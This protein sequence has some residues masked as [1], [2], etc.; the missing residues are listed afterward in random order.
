MAEV[1]ITVMYPQPSDLAKFERDYLDEHIPMAKEVFQKAGATRAVLTKITGSPMG[2]PAFCRI[3][4]IY[5]P[6]LQTLQAAAMSAEAQKVL[7][8]AFQ[9]S[10]GGPPTILIGEV[11]SIALS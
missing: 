4:E 1:R 7:G 8:H 3:A 5:F 9:I 6:N 10:S 11:D 2:T